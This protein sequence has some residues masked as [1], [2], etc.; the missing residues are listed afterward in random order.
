[1]D[2]NNFIG[3]G[4]IFLIM[5][6]WFVF[7]MP[8]E[9]ELLK[10][11]Q[12]QAARDSLA[13]IERALQ[14][15]IA[16]TEPI[17]AETLSD[18]DEQLAERKSVPEGLFTTSKET[19]IKDFVV[20]TPLY[21]VNFTNRGAAPTKFTLKKYDTW[22]GAPVQMIA[23]TTSAVYNFGFLTTENHNIDTQNLVFR[24]INAGSSLNLAENENKELQY[25][26][27]LEDG[28][29]LL[30]TY[31]FNGETYE[32]DFDVKFVNLADVI[33]GGD[34]DFGWT[35]GLNF[36]ERDI[37]QESMETSA[38]VYLA[39]ELQEFKLKKPGRDESNYFG[40]AEWAATRTKFFTQ[41]IKPRHEA[42]EALLTGEVTG[43]AKSLSAE[44]I[45]KSGITSNLITNNNTLSY[46]L[47]IGPMEYYELKNVDDNAYNMVKVSY[48]WLRFFS[49]PFVRFIIIPF[50]SFFGGFI[51]N[52]GIL[53]II[54]AVSVKLVLTPLTL[55]SYRSMAAMREIQPKVK[56]IQEKFKDNPQKLQQETMK[57]YKK[58][59][60]NPLGGCLPNL[61]QFPILITLWRFFQNSIILRQK[62]F[63]W[64]SDLSAP[65][66]II[67]LPFSI[68][69]IGESI[70]G[71]VLLMSATMIVQ[72]RLTGGMSTGGG[73]AM[74]Q[75]M[76]VMQYIF[77]VMMLFIFNKFAAGLSLYYL[78]FN[79][80]SIAQQY[81]INRSIKGSKETAVAK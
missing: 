67:N 42:K 41:I 73:G 9:E 3:F 4:L 75:Q 32:I 31:T 55:K 45:Y 79:A 33:I 30:Y 6:G 78:I 40:Q 46:I 2:K 25:V 57:L 69:F 16:E 58:E 36:T 12:E 43:D 62:S 56:E 74:A 59:K 34:V 11:K 7:T 52:Y 61:L 48:N 10:Q 35:S 63:L 28:R 66:F 5:I 54:F 47:F 8:S 17:K 60:V 38:Y 18:F 15:S 77:P 68:P 19:E 76:K 26:L 72:S 37:E 53:V 49:Q 50:F 65:D 21:R 1:M 22:N 80:L 71:F 14:D 44:H 29:Q 70:A 13:Q 51:S 64:A 27:E 81:F 24:Q 23:D 39:G 20:E